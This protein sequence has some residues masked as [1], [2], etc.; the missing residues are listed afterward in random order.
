M[1]NPVTIDPEILGGEPVFTGTRVPIRAF[2][3][4]IDDG[5][6]VAE[7]LEN[8]QT[9]NRDMIHQLFDMAMKNICS[10]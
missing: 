3:D 4:Y 1:T 7:F 5:M 2:F 9:V 6:C 8:Y 10:A